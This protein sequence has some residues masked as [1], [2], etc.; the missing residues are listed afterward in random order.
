MIAVL[1]VVLALSIA[2]MAAM[3]VYGLMTVILRVLNRRAPYWFVRYVIAGRGECVPPHEPPRRATLTLTRLDDDVV[4]VDDWQ[5][6]GE[7]TIK[8]MTAS[9]LGLYPPYDWQPE[10][11]I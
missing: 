10:E 8:P 5:W 4:F 7:F 2:V 3:V 11:D 1:K 6:G 9:A